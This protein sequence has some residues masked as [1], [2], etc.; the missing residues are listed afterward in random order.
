MIVLRL[1]ILK[2]IS[3]YI[4]SYFPL[5]RTTILFVWAW[6]SGFGCRGRCIFRRDLLPH[7][8]L[9]LLSG[10]YGKMAERPRRR[11]KQRELYLNLGA[12]I[13]FATLTLTSCWLLS[14]FAGSWVAKF[15][16][17]T[18]LLLYIPAQSSSSSGCQLCLSIILSYFLLGCF[19]AKYPGKPFRLVSISP[20]LSPVLQP[21]LSPAQLV[22]PTVEAFCWYE[23]VF[24]F[25]LQTLL[26]FYFHLFRAHLLWET[27]R[28]VL[29]IKTWE[30]FHKYKHWFGQMRKHT[31]MTHHHS[32]SV[33]SIFVVGRLGFFFLFT[34]R[35]PK[36][37]N[38]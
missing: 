38:N 18:L 28:N 3:K 14:A 36:L 12:G 4:S 1:E 23:V 9:T 13:S 31:A 16:S 30:Y 37:T 5:C 26:L 17:S 32:Q 21:S 8:W 35:L 19:N 25:C 24:F 11:R 34:T 2:F 29:V 27:F 6:F 33:R 22:W 7:C 15:F 10:E 20:S